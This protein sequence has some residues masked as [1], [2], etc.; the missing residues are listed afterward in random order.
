[1][2][3]LS[4]PRQH[5]GNVAANPQTQTV[6]DRVGVTADDADL[7]VEV[8]IVK[9]GRACAFR[10]VIRPDPGQQ[11]QVLRRYGVESEWPVSQTAP[12]SSR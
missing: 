8:L 6:Q 3:R 1:M 5:R 9:H 2:A 4:S 12:S 7:D 10:N 11:L